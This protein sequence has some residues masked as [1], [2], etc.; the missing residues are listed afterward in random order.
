MGVVL[1]GSKK[2]AVGTIRHQLKL[3]QNGKKCSR[4]LKKLC[5]W[6]SL[7]II[8]YQ[9]HFNDRTKT[10]DVD[11][12]NTLLRARGKNLAPTLANGCK[13]NQKAGKLGQSFQTKKQNKNLSGILWF[14]PQKAY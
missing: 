4:F 6:H 5:F 11:L 14:T 7:K 12:Y 8:R 1:C 3:G 2:A 9:E 13:Q 10:S